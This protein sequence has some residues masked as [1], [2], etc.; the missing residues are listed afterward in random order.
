M[1]TIGKDQQNG[2]D[3]LMLTDDHSQSKV[4][5]VPGCGAMLHA[6]MV[7]TEKETLN[8][9][10]SYCDKKQF[11]EKT[12]PEG[13]KGLK[14]SPFPCR[15]QNA[16]YTFN[17]QHY[18]LNTTGTNGIALH[19]LLFKQPFELVEQEATGDFARV[20]LVHK[21]KADKA[22][23]PFPYTCTVEYILE[24]ENTLK[25]ITTVKNTGPSA[26]PIADGWHPYFSFGRPVND[27]QLQFQS[28]E[29]LEFVNL[30]PSGKILP[31]K[32]FNLSATIGE[33]TLDNSFLLDFT[34]HQPMC[35][36]YDPTT[37]WQIEISPDKSYPYLQIY[38]PPHRK[39]IAIENLS[40]PPD[41]FNNGMGLITLEP[42]ATA[43]FSTQFAVRKNG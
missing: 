12:E 21:Y 36:L 35:I 23:Y 4:E 10:D 9:I 22:G 39:S 32:T 34:K 20:A 40:A 27:L 15:I 31:Y 11:D 7:Q 19:G 5:I 42:G 30:I 28:N 13:F 25:V 37:Q 26:M 29:M 8:V 41:S 16:A 18:Y 38:I 1:F 3:K 14:L 6:F 33:T 43:T 24:K 2:F 17:D